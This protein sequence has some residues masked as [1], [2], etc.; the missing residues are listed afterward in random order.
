M[1]AGGR[2]SAPSPDRR[3][4]LRFFTFR[5]FTTSSWSKSSELMT[6]NLCTAGWLPLPGGPEPLS[7]ELRELLRLLGSLAAELVTEGLQSRVSVPLVPAGVS[8]HCVCSAPPDTSRLARPEEE[9]GFLYRGT[10]Q[11]AEAL[12]ARC[13]PAGRGGVSDTRG[14]GTR[15]PARFRPTG[16][17]DQNS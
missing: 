7:V 13:Q 1:H 5:G 14:I 2:C 11:E 12:T 16:K 4:L 3:L 17:R 6:L 9:I 8:P 10:G 15:P